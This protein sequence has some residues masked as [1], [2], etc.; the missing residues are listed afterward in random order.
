MKRRHFLRNLAAMPVLVRGLLSSG[1]LLA[2]FKNAYA[3]SGK[4]LVV[5]FQ[6][7]GCD[8]L[9]VVVPHGEDEYYRL[10]P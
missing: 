1:A 2:G 4:T 10:R 6:R 7:G 9:N 8:G 3:A 5:I